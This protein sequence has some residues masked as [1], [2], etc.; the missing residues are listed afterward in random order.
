LPLITL[1]LRVFKFVWICPEKVNITLPVYLPSALALIVK[2]PTL[3]AVGTVNEPISTLFLNS[4][5]K[6]SLSLIN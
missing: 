5:Y 3:S 2:E 4:G 1:V 6:F